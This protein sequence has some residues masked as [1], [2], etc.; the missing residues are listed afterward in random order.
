MPK[1]S[2]LSFLLMQ[3]VGWGFNIIVAVVF[4]G[5]GS[6]ALHNFCFIPLACCV[7]NPSFFFFLGGVGTIHISGLFQIEAESSWERQCKKYVTRWQH[8]SFLSCASS[9]GGVASDLNLLILLRIQRI[10]GM[11]HVPC[12]LPTFISTYF[13]SWAK[14]AK[15]RQCVPCQAF[16]GR[17][18]AKSMAEYMAV[19]NWVSGEGGDQSHAISEDC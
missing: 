15:H 5:A 19:G 7:G 11:L 9:Y 4:G 18:Q 1:I 6:V 3:T 8:L 10:M 12:Q 17:K 13:R 14:R 16:G 2:L